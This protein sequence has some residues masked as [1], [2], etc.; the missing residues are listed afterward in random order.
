VISLLAA[1]ALALTYNCEVGAPR[2]LNIEGDKVSLSEIGLPPELAKWR[3]TVDIR[4]G[5]PPMAEVKWPGN[6]L[7]AEG[8]FAAISTG[9]NVYSFAALG[10]GPC[11]FTETMCASLFSIADQPG[12]TAKV[13]IEPTALWTDSKNDT[14]EPFVAILQGQ[15]SRT[16]TSG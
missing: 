8:K 16:G 15:C 2:S 11:L 5:S 14:R 3:F 1:A 10:A 12:G 13:L 9:K 4:G 7:H 6:P